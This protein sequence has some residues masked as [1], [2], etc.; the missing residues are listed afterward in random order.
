MAGFHTSGEAVLLR[1]CWT[2]SVP[3]LDCTLSDLLM[4]QQGH[5]DK[6]GSTVAGMLRG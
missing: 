5:V 2:A 1:L 6:L 3:A 4:L